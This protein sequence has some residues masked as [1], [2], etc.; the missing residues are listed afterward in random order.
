MKRTGVGAT[1]YSKRLT[2]CPAA[3]S[4]LFFKN[5]S[6]HTHRWNSRNAIQPCEFAL[7][8][9]TIQTSRPLLDAQIVFYFKMFLID[10]ICFRLKGGSDVMHK[11][12]D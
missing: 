4:A 11:D 3:T 10:I 6:S 1:G 9:N 8:T 2:Q 5:T 12:L 7:Q